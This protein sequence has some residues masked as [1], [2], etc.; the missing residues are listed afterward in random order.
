MLKWKF[1]TRYEAPREAQYVSENTINPL[2]RLHI[3]TSECPKPD[4]LLGL[5]ELSNLKLEF[6]L[7]LLTLFCYLLVVVRRGHQNLHQTMNRSIPFNGRFG[8]QSLPGFQSFLFWGAQR[9]NGD[10]KKSSERSAIG[11]DPSGA[12]LQFWG[13]ID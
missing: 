9:M 6:A 5:L 1:L 4:K 13:L 3:I 2:I 12:I 8:E 7:T 11:F 10:P